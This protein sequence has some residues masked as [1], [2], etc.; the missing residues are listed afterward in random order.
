MVFNQLGSC[1]LTATSEPVVPTP[2]AIKLKMWC[3]Y[4]WYGYK[5]KISKK[6]WEYIINGN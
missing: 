4:V 5:N 3:M 6:Y 1:G 2:I